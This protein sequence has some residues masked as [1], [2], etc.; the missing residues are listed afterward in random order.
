M[1]YVVT[2]VAA[3]ALVFAALAGLPAGPITLASLRAQPLD[4]LRSAGLALGLMSLAGVP[5][6]PGFW[7]KLGVLVPAFSAAGP[8]WT[9]LATTGGV[10]G[11]LYYLRPVPDLLAGAR[12]AAAP[13]AGAAAG[14]R[15]AVTVL[16]SVVL[17]LTAMPF[18]ATELATIV[19]K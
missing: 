19:G 16:A 6:S 13:E 9:I 18:L 17:V 3:A 7:A 10:L 4:R 14:S 2:Y 1:F 11:A 15:F 8:W 5:P 12:D